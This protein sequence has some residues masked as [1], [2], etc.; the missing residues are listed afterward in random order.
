[1]AQNPTKV[2]PTPNFYLSLIPLLTLVLMLTGSIWMFGEDALGGP[3][4]ISLLMA[5]A[6]SLCISIGVYR[7][8][9]RDVQATLADTIGNSSVS[10]V[11]LLLIGMM[12]GAWM[13]SGAVPTLIY[14]G[15]QVLSPTF[16]MLWTCII[17]AVVSIMTGSSWTTIATI[18]VALLGIGDALGVDNAWTAGAIISGAYFGDK[19]SPLSDTTVLA[20]NAAGVDVFVHIRYMMR[21][22]IPTI[23]IALVVFLI[24]GC[25]MGRGGRPDVDVYTQGLAATFH[26]TPWTLVVP[27]LT[28][29]LIVK[30]VPALVTLF[31][32]AIAAGIMAV[33]LQPEILAGIAGSAEQSA[34]SLTKGLVITFC[35]STHVDAHNEALNALIAT[36]G[37][38]GMLDTVWLI[39]CAMCFGGAMTGTGMLQSIVGSIARVVRGKTTLVSC[40]A[41]TGIG[42]NLMTSDQYMS[43]VLTGNMYRDVYRR[44]GFEGRLLSRTTEDST[45][46]TS[47]LVPWNTCGLTQATVLGVATLAYLPYCVFNYLSPVVTILVSWLFPK[48]GVAMPDSTT[49]N[50]AAPAVVLP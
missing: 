41:A 49:E 12:S 1:M 46:V 6:V 35:S 29:V 25:V 16:F 26:I 8:K 18:G 33:I 40:T 19:I 21:T 43:I 32:S 37:M 5:T 47:V 50:D 34:S 11:I 20:S 17:C 45:T 22:T 27:V 28:G 10:I 4:Q 42:L 48:T 2:L 13:I 14:Y 30:R 15:V 39:L 3:N 24:A 31:L 36:R 9:W 23:T 44:M 38:G 7:V